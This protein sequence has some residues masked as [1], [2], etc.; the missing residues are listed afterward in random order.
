MC[1]TLVTHWCNL[2]S[3][4]SFPSSRKAVVASKIE[5]VEPTTY[6]EASINDHWGKVILK[7]I[8]ALQHNGK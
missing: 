8:T 6:T 1:S 7:E 4:T 5:C 3:Y 2:V